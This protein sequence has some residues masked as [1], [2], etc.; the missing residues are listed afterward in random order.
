MSAAVQ[1]SPEA[2]IAGLWHVGD[3]SY[4]L[5]PHQEPIRDAVIAARARRFVLNCSRRLGK[6]NLLCTLAIEQCLQKPGSQVR[7]A[8]G[9]SDMVEEIIEPHMA[10]L[11]DDAPPD[12]EPEYNATKSRWTFPNGSSIRV[13]GCDDKRK[14]NRLRGR[15]CDLAIIDEAG[16]IDDLGYVIDDVLMPQLMTVNGQ[17]IISS[18]PPETPAHPFRAI[19]ADAQLRGAYIER[20]I[21]AATH[22]DDATRA[23]YRQE[24]NGPAW[25]PG[26]PDGTTWLRE[27][28]CQFVVDSTRAVLP[29]FTRVEKLIVEERERPAYF[30]PVI[31]ADIGYHDLTFVIGGYHDFAKGVDVIEWEYVTNKTIARDIDAKVS[32]IAVEHWGAR[33]AKSLRYA[34]APPI[35]IAEMRGWSG[36]AKTQTDGNWKAA[37]VNDVRTRLA[38]KSTRI[39]PRCEKLIA[40]CRYAVWKDPGRMLDR[41]DG[42]GHFDGVDALAYFT[43]L[44]DRHTNPMPRRDPSVTP[45]THWIEPDETVSLER[46]LAGRWQQPRSGAR[47]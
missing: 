40:H 38:E 42:F 27:Y 30:V 43:R 19:C 41:M 17:I 14:A 29:E 37:V 34:D 16:F 33:T 8:A 7:Y 2:A 35:V 22:I 15:A 3:L 12:L 36:I 21:Y 23:E 47:R 45:E 31:V 13:A 9:T 20:D 44:V 6:S 39:H 25:S 5:L 46:A 4:R 32:E 26:M 10:A 24:A 28:M 18:T 11:L 1:L